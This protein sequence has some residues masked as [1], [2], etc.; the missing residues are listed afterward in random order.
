[1]MK[2]INTSRVPD[3]CKSSGFYYISGLPFV[4]AI[5][6]KAKWLKPMANTLPDC[7]SPFINTLDTINDRA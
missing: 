3:L 4:P 6:M 5:L 7:V 1:M 2:L